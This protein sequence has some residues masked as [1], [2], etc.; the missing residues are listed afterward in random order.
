[1]FQ[2]DLGL[3][4]A[5]AGALIASMNLG[6]LCSSLG[7]G[8]LIDQRKGGGITRE[9]SAFLLHNDI[10]RKTDDLFDRLRWALGLVPVRQAVLV[11]MAFQLG[12]DGLLG[13]KNTLALVQRGEYEAAAK[14]M[15]NSKWATQTPE[16]AHRMSEQ[17]RLGRW[18][19]KPGY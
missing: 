12:V 13:F 4:R 14:G 8:R 5:Q 18:Q 16:R 10:D 7:V 3:S 15:L 11:A 6:P 1:L 9:E 19:F 17:M 2:S